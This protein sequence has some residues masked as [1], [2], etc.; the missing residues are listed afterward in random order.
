MNIS[1]TLQ[2]L[3]THNKGKIISKPKVATGSG[4]PAEINVIENVVLQSTTTTIVQ[5]GGF[6]FTTSY[7]NLPLPIDL[8]SRLELRTM[9]VL[10]PLLMLPLPVKQDQRLHRVPFLLPR[11]KRPI[12]P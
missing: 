2:A 10:L 6:Q 1:A 4:I 11:L 5:G 12:P 8:R 3:E 9:A 7:T